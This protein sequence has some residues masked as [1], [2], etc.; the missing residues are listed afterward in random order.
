MEEL[1]GLIDRTG[2]EPAHALVKQRLLDLIASGVIAE[3]TQLPSEPEVARLMGVSRMTANR[4][5]N[6]LTREGVL[7]RQQG[8]GTYVRNV[9]RAELQGH[10]T[11]LLNVDVEPAYDD[12]YFGPIFWRL[13]HR[14]H[15]LN[16]NLHIVR[17]SSDTLSQP[18]FQDSLGVLAITPEEPMVDDLLEIRRRG[19]PV[20][21]VG[22]TW[23]GHGLSSVD[24]DNRLGAAIAVNH[25][26]DL[27]H[28]RVQF[29]GGY[30][31]SS[32]T[33]DRVEGFRFAMK[34]RGLIVDEDRDIVIS[35][36]TSLSQDVAETI[37]ENLR[38]R[39]GPTGIFAAGPLLALQLIR[40]LSEAGFVIPID[41]SLVA[42]D[43]PSYLEYLNPS[44]TTIDQPLSAIADRAVEVLHNLVL[45]GDP[46]H[47]QSFVDPLLI[48]RGSSASPTS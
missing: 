14:F 4:A 22:A 12:Y 18:V 6:D 46:R 33:Q 20:V 45:S 8:K 23:P 44:V 27:G 11:V 37:L 15:A 7:E 2:T 41:V 43:N 40:F 5:L 29:V 36:R 28:R 48:R 13:H 39:P 9:R 38:S 17:H 47:S 31:E 42:Y 35:D 32:N 10:V 1:G 3:G 24:S 19:M 16:L 30:P 25:L 26:A 21:M 34:S